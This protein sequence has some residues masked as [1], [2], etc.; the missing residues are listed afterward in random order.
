MWRRS[1]A[2]TSADSSP[3]GSFTPPPQAFPGARYI[4]PSESPDEADWEQVR[5]L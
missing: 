2:R 4:R 3:Q 5:S 1:T